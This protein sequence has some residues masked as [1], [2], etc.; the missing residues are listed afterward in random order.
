[1]P[2]KNKPSFHNGQFGAAIAVHVVLNSIHDEIIGVKDDGSVLVN[3]SASGSEGQVNEKLL[4]LL[5]Q[6][7]SVSVGQLEIV[8][9]KYALDKLVIVIGR[10]SGYVQSKILN[11]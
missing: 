8:T 1:M 6:I 9:G 5:S 4:R 2:S 10:D 7:L 11:P 3:L